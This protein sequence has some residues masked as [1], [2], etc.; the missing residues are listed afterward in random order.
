MSFTK[1]FDNTPTE[2]IRNEVYL[3]L[4]A[5]DAGLSP[6]IQET[7]FRTYIRMED[8]GEMCIADKYGENIRNIPRYI[9]E[10][11]VEALWKL[12]SVHGIQYIDVT[13]Y[14]FIEKDDRLWVIDFGHA[15]QTKP[16]LD[17]YL[18]KT[19]AEWKIS[20]WNPRFK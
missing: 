16:T 12:Y 18:S 13:P 17:P 5:A 1:R 14:N 20:K 2:Q 3:Q 7:D 15:S 8:V 4:I 10:D 9:R 6:A 19:F 11:I